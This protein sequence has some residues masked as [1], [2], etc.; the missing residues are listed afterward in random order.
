MAAQLE[1]RLAR[2]GHEEQHEEW[3]APVPVPDAIWTRGRRRLRRRRTVS[4]VV[5]AALAAV[6]GSAGALTSG[7]TRTESVPVS[8]VRPA[9]LPEKLAWALPDA[10]PDLGRGEISAAGLRQRATGHLWWGDAQ[11]EVVGIQAATGT[12]GVIATPDLVTTDG[13]EGIS[14]SP[15]GA[16]LAY[17]AGDDARSDVAERVVVTNLVTGKSFDHDLEA[18]YGASVE[19]RGLRWLDADRLLVTPMIHTDADRN[20]SQGSVETAFVVESDQ[21]LGTLAAARLYWPDSNVVAGRHLADA[22]D[23]DEG[24][25]PDPVVVDPVTGDLRPVVLPDQ[26]EVARPLLWDGKEAV[27]AMLDST[28]NIFDDGE[29]EVA[30]ATLVR[31]RVGADCVPPAWQSSGVKVPD[32]SQVVGW[33]DGA[34]VVN[35]LAG[36]QTV[37]P[38]GASTSLIAFG[39]D[40]GVVDTSE[41]GRGGAVQRWVF[42]TDVLAEADVVAAT[43]PGTDPARWVLRGV[44]GAL[45]ALAGLGVVAGLVVALARRGRSGR[46]HP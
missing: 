18:P 35:T 34:A 43:E 5:A 27:V 15:D 10:L 23:S 46:G 40:D 32:W 26:S 8:T 41:W 31:C 24:D 45:A 36:L 17:W 16:S 30:F 4:V 42:A 44:P 3:H 1:E 13:V 28:P 21:T 37:R 6:I 19:A 38:Q 14:L 12:Y 7:V 11:V 25:S 29:A 9:V 22:D 39:P 33:R 2:L 20:A